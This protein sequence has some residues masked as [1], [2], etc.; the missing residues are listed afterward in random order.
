GYKKFVYH[1][2]SL[3]QGKE[4]VKNKLNKGIATLIL[5]SL[6][7][8]TIKH[9]INGLTKIGKVQLLST[10]F[11]IRNIQYLK[12]K[13]IKEGIFRLSSPIFIEDIN[14]NEL[15]P[16]DMQKYI[17]SN[18][19]QKYYLLND[20]LPEEMNIEIKFLDYQKEIV[21]YKGSR[22]NC[23]FGNI[24]IKGSEELINIAYKA[25]IGTKNGLGLGLLERI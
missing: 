11:E 25:G 3:R 12:D 15:T 21:N 24:A 18:L 7:D 19:I 8:D 9:F 13:D 5:S 16:C 2:Y 23:H 10:S 17:E 4:R 22:Y 1:T 20:K 14:H 6:V